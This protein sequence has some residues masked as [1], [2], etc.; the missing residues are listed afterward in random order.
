MARRGDFQI[1][2]IVIAAGFFWV[3]IWQ[4]EFVS[5]WSHTAF[6]AAV[7]ATSGLRKPPPPPPAPAEATTGSKR[8]PGK[9]TPKGASNSTDVTKD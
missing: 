1:W 4:H 9:V 2:W 8:P 7:A 3:V 6:T 5:K